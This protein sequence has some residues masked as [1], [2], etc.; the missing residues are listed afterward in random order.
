[1]C[2]N[3]KKRPAHGEVKE[4]AWKRRKELP[5]PSHAE[6]KERAWKRRKE[7]PTCE[8]CQYGAA[9]DETFPNRRCFFCCSQ[10]GCR[11]ALCGAC[12]GIDKYVGKDNADKFS[13]LG[14]TRTRGY[15]FCKKCFERL[16]ECRRQAEVALDQAAYEG[17][18]STFI[19][20]QNAVPKRVYRDA[21]R[22]MIECGYPDIVAS[23]NEQYKVPPEIRNEA[24]R[25]AAAAAA[26]V[27]G[28]EEQQD[29][30]R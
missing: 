24:I 16:I 15:C 27:A 5:R 14:W 8:N 22:Y 17:R 28:L 1:M 2:D 9:N 30:P 23:M 26:A 6:V 25:E 10:A 7:L 3:S 20:F 4:R 19:I 18:P 13:D 12:V 11:H 21:L 29:K